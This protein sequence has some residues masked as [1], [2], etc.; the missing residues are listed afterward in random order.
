MN[1]DEFQLELRG[2]LRRTEPDAA[3]HWTRYLKQASPDLDEFITNLCFAFLK[4]GVDPVRDYPQFIRN[5]DVL[6]YIESFIERQAKAIQA[7]G[8][9]ESLVLAL[10]AIAIIGHWSDPRDL[11][12]WIDDVYQA[13][14][15]AGVPEAERYF[16]QTADLISNQH[17]YVAKRMRTY[18]ALFERGQQERA[19]RIQGL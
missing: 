1:F 17:E 16:E 12:I 10:A 19:K 4:G 9:H 5:L 7:K 13:S 11:T 2:R 3:G 6:W 8:D 18:P 15:N 14:R